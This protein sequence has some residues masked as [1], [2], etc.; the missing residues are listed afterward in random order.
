MLRCEKCNYYTEYVC[1]YNKHLK[2]KKHL[3]NTNQLPPKVDGNTDEGKQKGC[4]LPIAPKSKNQDNGKKGELPIAP[5]NLNL[6]KKKRI[7]K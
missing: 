6:S 1:N 2:T 4:W 3:R 5:K 7:K